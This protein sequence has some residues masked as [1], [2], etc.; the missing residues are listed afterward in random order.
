MYIKS[1]TV[2]KARASVRAA[3]VL[4]IHMPRSWVGSYTSEGGQDEPCPPAAGRVSI[5]ETP[6]RVVRAQVEG[7]QAARH[8]EFE[9]AE[10]VP[11]DRD[12]GG[13]HLVGLCALAARGDVWKGECETVASRTRADG[14][15]RRCT[16]VCVDSGA[17]AVVQVMVER[18]SRRA[19]C[20]P[21]RNHM[22]PTARRVTRAS[23]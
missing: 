20:S 3:V 21:Q 23:A 4:W 19:H 12:D 15:E 7:Y 10:G 16:R 22:G 17:Y 2:R 8:D 14:D 11:R 6:K 18:E 1:T 9:L 5:D 13:G